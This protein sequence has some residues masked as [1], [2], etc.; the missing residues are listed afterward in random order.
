MSWAIIF[1]GASFAMRASEYLRLTGSMSSR[2]SKL[3][4]MHQKAAKAALEDAIRTSDEGLRR[5]YIIRAVDKYRDAIGAEEDDVLGLFG[6][7]VGLATCHGLLNDIPNRN[8]AIRKALECY[9]EVKEE[10][11]AE[12]QGVAE[13]YGYGKEETE[14][15]RAAISFSRLGTIDRGMRFANSII[16]KNARKKEEKMRGIAEQLSVL[17]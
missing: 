4:K 2:I 13:L 3:E 7:Y 10:A 17:L 5:Q 9:N 16:I 12:P 11:D 15:I 14:T 1:S 8:A 6:A